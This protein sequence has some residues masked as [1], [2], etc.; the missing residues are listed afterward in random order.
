MMLLAGK[1]DDVGWGSGSGLR[2]GLLLWGEMDVERGIVGVV[3]RRRLP[4]W[5]RIIRSGLISYR[6]S[7]FP[8][9]TEGLLCGS[10]A[11]GIME[12]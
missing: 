9:S 2:Y 11:L 12:R 7:Q 6:G 3:S 10:N 5:A 4:E 8:D 1:G